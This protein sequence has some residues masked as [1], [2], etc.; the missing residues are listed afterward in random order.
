[1]KRCD[2][3]APR[4]AEHSCSADH[5]CILKPG[6]HVEHTDGQCLWPNL[7]LPEKPKTETRAD[8]RQ[9]VKAIV[10]STTRQTHFNPLRDGP[11]VRAD[12]P[13]NSHRAA[14]LIEPARGT[15]RARVLGY[16][17]QHQGEWVDA[18][19]LTGEVG[20]FAGTRRLRELRDQGWPIE[21][22]EKPEGVNIWQHRL[23]EMVKQ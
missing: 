16:L 8:H 15:A 1:M 23:G 18:V 11:I 3:E 10:K 14:E 20:G 19:A 7:D 12:D 17:R 22:R 9:Q 4:S 13:A 6:N 2:N 21:T 5:F